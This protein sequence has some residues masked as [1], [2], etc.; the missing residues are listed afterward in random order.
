MPSP[1]QQ[2]MARSAVLGIFATNGFLFAIWVVH[3]PE[4][5]GRAGVSHAAL[6]WLL[7]LMGGSAITVSAV[8]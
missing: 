2:R 1:R 3:I 6:G 5:T 8:I 7:L 4:I